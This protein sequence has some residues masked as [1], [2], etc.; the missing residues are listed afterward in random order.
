MARKRKPKQQVL[1]FPQWGGARKGT[2]RKRAEHLGGVPHRSRDVKAGGHPLHVTLRL[3]RGLPS[4]RTKAAHRVLLGALTTGLCRFGFSVVHYSALSNHVHL[5]CEADGKS[6]LTLGMNALMTRIARRLNRLWKRKGS[7]FAH[8]YHCRALST[9]LEC[10]RGLA[11]VL[12]NPSRHGIHHPGGIDPY[13]SAAWFEGWDPPIGSSAPPEWTIPLPKAKTWLLREGWLIHG[14][15][16]RAMGRSLETLN[17]SRGKCMRDRRLP[18]RP[19]RDGPPRTARRT[20]AP[21]PS[22]R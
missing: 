2:G 22:S 14:R 19:D 8:R 15:L 6:A 17:A 4:L 9:P 5:L 10:H 12:G 7:V 11:Y 20:P 18:E 1:D 3:R 21:R 13:S 16:P